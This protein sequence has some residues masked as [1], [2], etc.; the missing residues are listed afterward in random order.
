MFVIIEHDLTDE[1]VGDVIGP[2]ETR[3]EAR[4]TAGVLSDQHH[5]GIEFLVKEVTS[6]YWDDRR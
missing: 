3:E 1:L 4:K 2:F 5:Y 6:K